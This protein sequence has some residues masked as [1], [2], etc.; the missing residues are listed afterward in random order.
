MTIKTFNMISN[1]YTNLGAISWH[2]GAAN[3]IVQRGGRGLHHHYLFYIHMDNQFCSESLSCTTLC[4]V[5]AA[6]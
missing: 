2:D 3:L 4:I 1:S 5:G 6:R